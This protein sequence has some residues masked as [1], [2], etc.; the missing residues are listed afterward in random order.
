MQKVLLQLGLRVRVRGLV[1]ELAEHAQG[2]RVSLLGALAQ[3]VELHGIGGFLVPIGHDRVSW[4]EGSEAATAAPTGA[5]KLTT[6]G[7]GGQKAGA[8]CRARS[9]QTDTAAKRLT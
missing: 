9:D 7:A 8:Q 6:G 4:L 5:Q 3:A 1:V 2:A